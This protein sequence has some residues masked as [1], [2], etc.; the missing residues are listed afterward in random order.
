MI[1]LLKE[2]SDQFTVTT[3]SISYAIQCLSLIEKYPNQQRA[4]AR[5][6]TRES[7][8]T[9]LHH[10]QR[11]IAGNGHRVFSFLVPEP[12]AAPQKR[13]FQSRLD[14]L[15]RGGEPIHHGLSWRAWSTATVSRNALSHAP[16]R[17]YLHAPPKSKSSPPLPS[18]L[19]Y[20][21]WCTNC[22]VS[23][24][25]LS[26]S[27]S[28]SLARGTSLLLPIFRRPGRRSDDRTLV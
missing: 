15:L 6:S 14:T 5:Q 10:L 25:C 23:S 11:S 12:P 16:P 22:V 7:S 26:L 20:A 19:F 28:V 17:V 27:R 9:N 13:Y 18:P 1:L 8:D 24:R 3:K 4:S 2:H 21:L